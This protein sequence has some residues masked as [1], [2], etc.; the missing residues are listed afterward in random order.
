MLS[1]AKGTKATSSDLPFR[2]CCLVLPQRLHKILAN[3]ELS[4][5]WH[6][7]TSVSNVLNLPRGKV[8]ERESHPTGKISNGQEKFSRKEPGQ[9]CPEN[10]NALNCNKEMNTHGLTLDNE[11]DQSF[12]WLDIKSIVLA[13]LALVSPGHLP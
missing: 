2:P 12:P 5:N 6:P 4:Q 1:T 10:N 3:S 9:H 8:C 11:L 13:R 7:K